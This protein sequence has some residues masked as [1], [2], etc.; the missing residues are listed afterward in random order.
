MRSVRILADY[1]C[2]AL[3][4]ADES[5]Y[6]N[7]APS[8]QEIGLSEPLARD[9]DHWAAEYSATLR[10]DDPVNSGFESEAAENDFY[11]RGYQLASRVKRELGE[12]WQ[13]SYFDGVLRR[14]VQIENELDACTS[15]SGGPLMPELMRPRG[16]CKGAVLSAEAEPG[17]APEADRMRWQRVSSGR[18]FG[19]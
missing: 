3:W 8:A 19:A 18:G 16:R 5:G 13:V 12:S 9:L 2:F 4:V 1:Y 6:E 10:E 14:D 7:I 15:R 11:A 17:L